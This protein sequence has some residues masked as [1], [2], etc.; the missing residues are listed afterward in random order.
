MTDYESIDR[1]IERIRAERLAQIDERLARSDESPADIE[2]RVFLDMHG[3]CQERSEKAFCKGMLTGGAIALLV[4][5][6]TL[7]LVGI[8]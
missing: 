2:Q 4:Y 5:N 8:L 7:W 6:L 3:E 1:A